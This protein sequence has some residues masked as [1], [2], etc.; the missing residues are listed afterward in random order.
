[1]NR[2]KYIGRK[3]NAEILS[4]QNIRIDETGL[5]GYVSLTKFGKVYEPLIID[6][7]VIIDDCFSML[8][9]L[10]D[11]EQWALETMY[12]NND[13]MIGWWYFDITS[14][15]SIDEEGNPY[16][17]DL[18]LDAVLLA[19][20]QIIICDEDELKDAF[21]VGEITRTE[22]DMAYVTLN[23]LK[24]KKIIDVTHI[25]AF[26]SRLKLLFK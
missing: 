18:F 19:D 13:D 6:N 17:D 14:N 2:R 5:H 25:T 12:D 11:N 23:S 8:E 20:G 16:Y 1:M 26:C 4:S 22:F 3:I 24:E 9:F 21:D 10:P 7:F 15:N